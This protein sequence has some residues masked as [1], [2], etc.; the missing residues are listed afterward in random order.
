M[1]G[2][3]KKRSPK[4]RAKGAETRHLV[5]FAFIMAEKLHAKLQTT[6]SQT[7]ENCM[8]YLFELYILMGVR[9]WQQELAAKACRN[10]LQLYGALM[11]EAEARGSRQW[12]IKPKAHM[13]Q[14]LIEFQAAEFG[15]PRDFWAYKDEDFVG[16][17]SETVE[18]RGGPQNPTTANRRLVDRYRALASL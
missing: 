15:N 18:S 12:S 14:E 13:M 16:F 4:L 9:P 2:G 8:L 6:H 5:P 1:I 11:R 7:V 3:E 10:C 17:A